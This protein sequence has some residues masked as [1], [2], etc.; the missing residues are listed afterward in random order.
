MTLIRQQGVLGS[1]DDF[2]TGYSGLASLRSLPVDEL[3]IDRSF[4]AELV[5]G[6]RRD[7]LLTESIVA[8]GR[9]FDLEVVAEGVEDAATAHLLS[10]MGCTVL[11]GFH[12]GKPMPAAEA[13][14]LLNELSP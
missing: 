4:V 3:K 1:L 8:M 6:G 12:L 9:G 14:Q 13:A 7:R 11:Q 5:A 10:Q 2:G